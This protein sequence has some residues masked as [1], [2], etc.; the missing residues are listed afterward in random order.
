MNSNNTDDSTADRAPNGFE[1]IRAALEDTNLTYQER[2]LLAWLESRDYD[3]GAPT[4]SDPITFGQR[5]LAAALFGPTDDPKKDKANRDK[6]GDL[7]KRLE[8]KGYVLQRRRM[9][10]R[11]DGRTSNEIVLFRN[12]THAER[13][14]RVLQAA[15][16]RAKDNAN[17]KSN[18]PAPEPQ[19]SRRTGRQTGRNLAQDER[20][21]GEKLRGVPGKKFLE[22]PGVF[23]LDRKRS[24]ERRSKKRV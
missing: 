2:V 18:W 12:L 17:Q 4:V 9:R 14:D 3:G 20:V 1:R 15:E 7:L 22:V 21:P 19:D 5:K 6:I 13:M 8:G 16:Q 11:D 23:L 24:P 10:G